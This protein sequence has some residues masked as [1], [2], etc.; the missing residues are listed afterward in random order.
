MDVNADEQQKP[1][2]PKFLNFDEEDDKVDDKIEEI[3]TPSVA[4]AEV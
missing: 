2:A 4:A 3:T 1:Y